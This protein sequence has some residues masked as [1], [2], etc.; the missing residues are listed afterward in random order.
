MKRLLW[1]SSLILAVCLLACDDSS[2]AGDDDA[3]IQLSSDSQDVHGSSEGDVDLSSSSNTAADSIESSSSVSILGGKV[4]P[5]KQEDKDDCEYGEL[6]DSR[7]AEVYKTVKIGNQ[8]W[9]AE[10]LRYADS[11]ET[12]NLKGKSWC[13][14][15]KS[16]S[17]EKYGRLYAWS[18]SNE[19][20]PPKWHLPTV[21]EWEELK[22][23]TGSTQG[24]NNNAGKNLKSR[25]GWNEGNGT[26]AYGFTVLPSGLGSGVNFTLLGNYAGFWTATEY[27]EKNSS[28]M[29]ISHNSHSASISYLSKTVGNSI[30]CVKD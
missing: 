17:C 14:L 18:V 20:C 10:N 26:D 29:N 3:K 9:M 24:S 16:E 22:D 23:N 15:N 11:T 25:T 8:W 4:S 12:E 13:Y 2:S 5:C 6:I 30:R 27:D 21:A 1:I 7:D 19:V 28:N